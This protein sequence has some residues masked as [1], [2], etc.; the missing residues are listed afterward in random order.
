MQNQKSVENRLF[1]LTNNEK[2]K[3]SVTMVR[4]YPESS[5]HSSLSVAEEN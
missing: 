4:P 5:L 1:G 3:L 2:E